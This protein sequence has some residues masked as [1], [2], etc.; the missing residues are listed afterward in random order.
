QAADLRQVVALR[1]EEQVVEEL[2]RGL[3][4]GRI[5]RAQTT[6]DLHDGVFVRLHLLGEERVAQV[7]AD[8]ETVDEEDLELVDV[9]V[10]ELVQLRRR[11]LLVALEEDFARLVV[12]DVVS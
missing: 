3:E 1:V 10:A 2:L 12:D 11:E 6:I 9:R 7:A 8:V 4:R 5:A